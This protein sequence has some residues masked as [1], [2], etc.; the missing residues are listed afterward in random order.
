M[1]TTFPLKQVATS[2]E[3]VQKYV[4]LTILQSMK[5]QRFIIIAFVVVHATTIA[6]KE[7]FAIKTKRAR[8][9]IE[10]KMSVWQRS[11]LPIDKVTV[12]LCIKPPIPLLEKWAVSYH[13]IA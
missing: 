10:T 13:D 3:Y 1:L 4:L 11:L 6:H 8:L 5:N 9:N 7:L 12:L 2:V